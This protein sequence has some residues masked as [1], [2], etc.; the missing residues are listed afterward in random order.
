MKLWKN[1]ILFVSV[2]VML[3]S[4]M[5]VSAD[6]TENDPTGDVA[7]WAGSTTGWGWTDIN[8]ADRPNIDIKELRQNVFGDS[9]V[10]ELEVY[11]SI[12][13]SEKFFYWIVFNSSDAYYWVSWTNG[14]GGGIGM[15]L[16][17]VTQM[18]QPVVTKEGGTI[19]ATFDIVGEDTTTEE[20]WGYAWEYTT[21][22]DVITSEWWGDWVPND[23]TP[24][25]E[26]DVIDEG[27]DGTGDETDGEDDED[28]QQNPPAGTPGFEAIA[29]LAAVGIAL[30]IL[31]RR[32]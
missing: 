24:F 10:I 14:A 6:K 23:Y 13:D 27:D 25:D 15:T 21:L 16:G 12:Q 30:I 8:I 22:G 11:G 29:V 1:S 3:L 17:D 28:D 4:S 19:T 2:A 5:T 7:H 32:K 26:E 20:F 9:M 18:S 31:R